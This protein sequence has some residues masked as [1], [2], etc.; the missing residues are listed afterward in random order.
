MGLSRYPLM[1]PTLVHR[2]KSIA[3]CP[4]HTWA[5]SVYLPTLASCCTYVPMGIPVYLLTLASCCTYVPMGI[6]CLLTNIGVLLYVCAYG[7]PLSTYQ[8]WRLAVRMWLWAS[9]VHL[10]T[11]ASC[12][13][14]VAMGIPCLLTNIGVLL[15]VYVAR[16][17]VPYP[18]GDIY[19]I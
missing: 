19:I 12:C 5:S 1:C 8:H 18:T 15:Y 7:H 11:L 14:Y 2:M 13:T 4:M 17:M 10:P 6:P 9:P 16:I 3:E